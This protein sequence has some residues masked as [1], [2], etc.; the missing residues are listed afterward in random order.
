MRL[1]IQVDPAV[2]AGPVPFANWVRAHLVIMVAVDRVLIRARKVRPIYRAGVK[3]REEPKGQETFVD[4]LTCQ[5]RGYGD[6]AHLAA[7]RCA[8]LQETG[9]KATLRIQ[10]KHPVYHVQV[11]RQNRQIED[12]SALL[13]MR[14]L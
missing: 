5:R 1:L 2:F 13:G 10:W 4:A 6:C 3:F 9:E 11:R 8:E 14:R 12:P 7:W